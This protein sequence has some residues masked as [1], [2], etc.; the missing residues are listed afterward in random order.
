VIRCLAHGLWGGVFNF[1]LYMEWQNK[2][3]AIPGRD[4]VAGNGGG[5]I[6][7]GEMGVEVEL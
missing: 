3:G 5:A 1:H 2:R 6:V 4:G 7:Y